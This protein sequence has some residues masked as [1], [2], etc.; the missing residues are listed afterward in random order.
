MSIFFYPSKVIYLRC[1]PHFIVY[2][3]FSLL[4]FLAHKRWAKLKELGEDVEKRTL[5]TMIDND[6]QL[7]YRGER[8]HTLLDTIRDGFLGQGK[9][10]MIEVFLR[11]NNMNACSDVGAES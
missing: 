3:F 1:F 9:G 10:D 6:V 2:S 11:K 5:I 7:Q 8:Q 4:L